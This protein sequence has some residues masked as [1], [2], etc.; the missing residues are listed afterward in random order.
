MQFLVKGID[1]ILVLLTTIVF[2]R[3]NLIFLFLLKVELT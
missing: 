3:L 2:L 1:L